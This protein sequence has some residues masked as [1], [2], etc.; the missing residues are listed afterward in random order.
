MKKIQVILTAFFCLSAIITRSQTVDNVKA[1]I[2]DLNNLREKL[3]VEKLY[4]QTDKPYYALGDT[5]HFKSYLLNADFLTPSIRSG[6]LYIELDNESSHMVKRIMIPVIAGISWGDIALNREEIPE[7]SY[8]LRAYTNWMR[9]F[10]EDYI[11]KKDIYISTLGGATLVNAAFKLDTTSGKNKVQANLGFSS[12]NKSPLRLKDMRLKVMDGRHNLFKD[13]ANTGIDGNT[14]INFDIAD[15]T[16]INSLSIQAAQSGK[17]ADTAILNIPVTLNRPEKTDVQFMPEGGSIIAG[18][19]VRI[20]F[21]A[22]SEDGKGTDI[23]GRIINSK[24]QIIATIKSF[25]KGMGSFEFTPQA[26]ESY[27]AVINLTDHILKNY[28]LP[29]LQT[30]GT[31]LKVVPK[32]NDSLMITCAQT[33]TTSAVYYLIAQARD[34]VC[35][36]A[37]IVFSGQYNTRTIAKSLF[38][39]GV[40]RF[41]LLNTNG[42]PLNERIVYINHHDELNLTIDD[43]KKSYTLRDSIGLNLSVKNEDGKPVRGIFSL[44]VTDDDQVQLDSNRSNIMNNLLFTSDLKGTVEEPGWYFENDTPEKAIALDNLLLT[45]GWV[46]YD[47][48]QVFNTSGQ[49]PKYPAEKEFTIQGR[50]TNLFNKG[51]EKSQVVLLGRSPQ[52]FKDTVTDKD[53]RF[54]FKNLFPVDT[55]EFKLEARNKKGKEFNVGIEMENEFIE[56]KFTATKQ[57]NPWYVNSDSTLLKN[58]FTQITQ[59]KAIAE[60]KGEGHLLKEVVIKDKKIIKDSKN[61]NGPGESDQAIDEQEILKAKK[62]TL[63]DLLEKKV[64]GFH[65]FGLWHPCPFCKAIATSYVSDDKL[66]IFIF[67]GINLNKLDKG[68]A[69]GPIKDPDRH[70]FLKGYMDY[71]TAEEIKGIEV[72]NNSAYAANYAAHYVDPKFVSLNLSFIEITTRSGHGPF[73]KITPGTYL[74]KP[75]PYTLP[76]QFYRPRYTPKNSNIAMGTD[77]RSTIHWEPNIITDTNGKA[78]VSFFSADKPGNYSIIIEGSDLNGKLGYKTKRIKIVAK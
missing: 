57:Q 48:K 34:V 28:P 68:F 71:F 5:L 43:D 60:Y 38:P 47:W 3:P 66:I 77:L 1:V 69:L 51:V 12:L 52:V 42:Q 63:G 55:A 9:N 53:G 76:K 6:L 27:A 35:Y 58:T 32:G 65:E 4:L 50:V 40:A 25:H 61:I 49:Q 16:M 75:L 46:G 73:M 20:G 30:A 19:P 15:K 26:G 14:A 45:Q 33:A 24:K 39:T 36:A 72:M 2:S 67:D 29:V 44:A 11:Y 7:G 37:A 22:I 62:T 56:P 10:G 23:S 59:Q 13:Q 21:K 64:K 41:T 8:T 70:V 54:M 74:Y 18:I 31:A 78:A 17:D